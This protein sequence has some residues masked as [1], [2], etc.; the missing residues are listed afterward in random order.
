[1]DM[2][3][4]TLAVDRVKQILHYIRRPEPHEQLSAVNVIAV[5]PNE[6]RSSHLALSV[7]HFI[8]C[9]RRSKL[10]MM[11][12]KRTVGTLRKGC[13]HLPRRAETIVIAKTRLDLDHPVSIR[14]VFHHYVSHGSETKLRVTN[15]DLCR[16]RTKL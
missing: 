12:M 3:L 4:E 8:H 1:M 16:N 13:V 2:E 14:C 6:H 11:L 10:Q 9:V 5:E 15:S 7:C